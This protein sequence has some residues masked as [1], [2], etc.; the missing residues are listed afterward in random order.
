MAA[1]YNLYSRLNI[2]ALPIFLLHDDV[3]GIF[4][5]HFITLPQDISHQITSIFLALFFLFLHFIL[6]LTYYQVSLST[7]ESAEVGFH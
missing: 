6:F 4:K 7:Y 1:D 2:K 3:L 5:L